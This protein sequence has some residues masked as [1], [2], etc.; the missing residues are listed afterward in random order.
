[1][2]Y[3]ISRGKKSTVTISVTLTPDE[4]KPFIEQGAQKLSEQVK[5]EGFRP[6]RAP[7]DIV[8]AKVGEQAIMTEAADLAI[9][10]FYIEIIKQEKL[11]PIGSPEI[12]IEKL[13]AGNE[14]V[15]T[16]TATVLP[17]VEVGD[18]AKVKVTEKDIV[19]TDEQ[20]DKVIGELREQRASEVIVTRAAKN[21]DRVEVDFDVYRDGV[22]I[23]GGAAKKYPLV[24]GAKHFIPGFEEAV[25]GMQTGETKEFELAFPK[26]YHAKQ[27]AGKPALF[28]VKLLAVYERSLPAVDDAFASGFGFKTAGE[29]RDQITHNLYHEEESKQSQ[30]LDLELIEKIVEKSK[31]GEL[32]D[33]LINAEVSKMINEL[34]SQIM[35]QGASFPDYLAGI[36]KT[37]EDLKLD[38]IPQAQKRITSALV[39]RAIFF[40]EKLEVTDADIT[41]EIAEI[42]RV[43]AHDPSVGTKI[44]T[45]EYRDYLENIIGNRKVMERLRSVCMVSEK[46]EH[47]H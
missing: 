25:V 38:F 5:I 46:K 19:V 44:E 35:M 28:K 26:D 37:E 15:F 11:E 24:L 6:G 12:G 27:L 41:A 22:P 14:L 13:A 3:K 23:D 34:R 43:Y 16:A 42:K 30:R 8:K 40:K 47:V 21:G 2:D 32:P 4:L 20:T 7:M 17:A 39:T 36:K 33:L 45:P 31:I 29:L 1:M 9:R 18:Y 10:H